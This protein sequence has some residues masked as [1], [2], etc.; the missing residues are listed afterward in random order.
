MLLFA[1]SRK[2]FNA[3]IFDIGY[4]LFFIEMIMEPK[5]RSNQT[6]TLL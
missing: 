6:H 1:L 4:V 5:T 3:G 2:W